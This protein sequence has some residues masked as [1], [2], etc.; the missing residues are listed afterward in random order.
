MVEKISVRNA[1]TADALLAI[2][3]VLKQ[4]KFYLIL[5]LWLLLHKG[6]YGLV[7]GETHSTPLIFS[8][9]NSQPIGHLTLS[10][11]WSS[12]LLSP[13]LPSSQA[14]CWSAPLYALLVPC[15]Y[16]LL[17]QGERMKI[18]SVREKWYNMEDRH[19]LIELASL[20]GFQKMVLWGWAISCIY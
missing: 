16:A 14:T 6:K 3:F 1:S 9:W 18:I 7:K 5:S 8:L 13:V 20:Y 15:V 11:H 19:Q 17:L 12:G 10:S 2:V 4:T